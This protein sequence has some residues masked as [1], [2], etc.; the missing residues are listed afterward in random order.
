[1]GNSLIDVPAPRDM[2]LLKNTKMMLDERHPIDDTS[3]E[4]NH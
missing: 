3:Q 4:V 1:M 2:Q